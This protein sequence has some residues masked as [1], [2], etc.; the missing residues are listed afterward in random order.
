MRGA[1][2]LAILK[3]IEADWTQPAGGGSREKADVFE[4]ETATE[5]LAQSPSG[6]WQRVKIPS[7]SAGEFR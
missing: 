1:S 7:K 3:A 5:I 4:A 2:E 6:H